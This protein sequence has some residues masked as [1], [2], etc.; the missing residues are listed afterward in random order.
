MGGWIEYP[1]TLG[2]LVYVQKKHL[3]WFLRKCL[4]D[5]SWPGMVYIHCLNLSKYSAK[6]SDS[7]IIFVKKVLSEMNGCS[8]DLGK[9]WTSSDITFLPGKPQ[10]FWGC[11][12]LVLPQNVT[13]LDRL[14]TSGHDYAALFHIISGTKCLCQNSANTVASQTSISKHCSLKILVG[15]CGWLVC[16]MET[17]SR[18][19]KVSTWVSIE[20][21]FS[22]RWSQK[23]GISRIEFGKDLFTF[24]FFLM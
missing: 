17:R 19:F 5:F 15:F 10:E 13:V 12:F 14:N 7:E 24:L 4:I 16:I 3:M 20:M 11:S 2:I 9:V 1:S 18:F 21:L 23:F 22:K 8:N 6:A